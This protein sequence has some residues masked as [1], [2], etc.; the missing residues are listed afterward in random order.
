MMEQERNGY[1]LWNSLEENEDMIT[2]LQKTTTTTTTT[3]KQKHVS[4][5]LTSAA[6]TLVMAQPENRWSVDPIKR[7]STQERNA[8]ESNLIGN[9]SE[10]TSSSSWEDIEVATVNDSVDQVMENP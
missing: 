6:S 1:V 8:L 10:Y 3:T 4:F 7:K 2:L 9:E 5:I